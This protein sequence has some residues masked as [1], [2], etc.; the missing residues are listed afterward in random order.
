MGIFH[1]EIGTFSLLARGL[2][3]PWISAPR[4]ALLLQKMLM[5]MITA[6]TLLVFVVSIVISL[7]L[8]LSLGVA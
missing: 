8:L 4:L 2:L 6:V 7:A 1:W 3:V 5:T